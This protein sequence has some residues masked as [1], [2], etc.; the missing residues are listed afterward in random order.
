MTAYEQQV[1]DTEKYYDQ[2]IHLAE[3]EAQ[4]QAQEILNSYVPGD[5]IHKIIHNPTQE[6]IDEG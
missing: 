1:L 5:L 4:V 6:S 2:A 3:S